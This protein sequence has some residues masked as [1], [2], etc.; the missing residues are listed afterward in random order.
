M[1]QRPS[2]RRRPQLGPVCRR[3][4]PGL[5][6][7][8][9]QSQASPGGHRHR[10]VDTQDGATYSMELRESP[11]HT[12]IVLAKSRFHS[13]VTLNYGA[14]GLEGI[15]E[16]KSRYPGSQGWQP[17]P[18]TETVRLLGQKGP[19]GRWPRGGRGVEGLGSVQVP[20]W[21]QNDGASCASEGSLCL[22]VSATTAI[23][24]VVGG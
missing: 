20:R 9:P 24:V 13:S 16:E 19:T 5:W 6:S 21:R 1:K 18:C 23:M 17:A 4:C 8:C 7:S 10:G 12:H 3:A 14:G 15:I 11:L 22:A 2:K